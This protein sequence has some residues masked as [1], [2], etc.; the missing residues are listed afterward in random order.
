MMGHGAQYAMRPGATE[1]PKSALCYA[2]VRRQK[3]LI[4]FVLRSAANT[5]EG[6]H[7]R[8]SLHAH[9]V[10][11]AARF[12]GRAR[13][14]RLRSLGVFIASHRSLRRCTFSQKSGLLPNTRAR[15]KRRRA[16]SRSGGR[17]TAR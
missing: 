8:M 7:L 12:N 6:R 16:R 14:I 9:H 11:H 2:V 10:T 1:R 15:I 4:S 13:S 3:D 17:C 5:C